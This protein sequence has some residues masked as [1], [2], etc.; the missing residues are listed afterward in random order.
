M[1][2]GR[3]NPIPYLASLFFFI[4]SPIVLG[5]SPPN[6]ESL[7][8]RL[9]E[10]KAQSGQAHPEIDS[11][12]GLLRAFS[13]GLLPDLTK[14]NQ[15]QAF[16][17]Y[18]QTKFGRLGVHYLGIQEFEGQVNRVVDFLKEHPKL[19][20]EPFRSYRLVID[21]VSYPVTEEVSNL[22][23]APLDAVARTKGNFYQI[24]ANLG[25]WKRLFNWEEANPPSDLSPEQM[26]EFSQKEKAR[27]LSF[28]DRLVTPEQ[29]ELISDRNEV[30][31]LAKVNELK[32][33]LRALKKERNKMLQKEGDVSQ[34]SRAIVELVHLLG[35]QAVGVQP[36]LKSS[37]GLKRLEDLKKALQERDRISTSVGF[38]N[39][40]SMLKDFKLSS[41]IGGE[42]QDSLLERIKLHL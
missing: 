4:G 23:R 20:K 35:F 6:C 2:A 18:L 11:W 7:L 19:N 29:R 5:G 28:L 42:P 15:I 17:I 24:E 21:Q 39:Y 41:I 12:E 31:E 25:F 8:S 32:K 1:I 10:E 16:K 38:E 37:D 27:F 30:S 22:M 36:N 40:N 26:K 33:F 34:I 13:E 3:L 14:S 9:A